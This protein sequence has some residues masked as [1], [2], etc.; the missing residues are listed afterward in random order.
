MALVEI[1]GLNFN[2]PME[3][4]KKIK[5][6]GVVGEQQALFGSMLTRVNLSQENAISYFLVG[7]K[8][9]VNIVVKLTHCT[10]LPQ[11]YKSA[12]IQEAYL[13]A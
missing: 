13:E 9:E 10:T 5:Q 7:H 6:T 8:K 3:E 12:S 4:I 2:G 11:L 1:F